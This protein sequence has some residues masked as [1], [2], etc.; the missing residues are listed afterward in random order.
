MAKTMRSASLDGFVPLARSCGLDPIKLLDKAGIPRDC[1]RNPDLRLSIG[2]Y[3]SLLE[4]SAKAAGADDFGVRL[5]ESRQLST[6][7]PVG[8]VVRE[9]PTVRKAIQALVDNIRLHNDS[10]S[11]ELDEAADDISIIKPDLATARG[12]PGAQAKDMVLGVVC[13][14]LTLL[15][16]PTWRPQSVW[17][18]RSRPA[19]LAAFRRVFGAQLEFNQDFNGIVCT[20][21]DI[22]QPIAGADPGMAREAER[23]VAL[24][25][26][27]GRR[28]GAEDIRSIVLTLLPTGQCTVEQVARHLG[29]DRRTVHRHLAAQDTTFSE[30]VDDLR[31]ELCISY[32][33]HGDRSLASVAELLGFSAQ[34]AFAHWHQERYGMSATARRVA[35]RRG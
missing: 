31:H 3:C 7:G 23:Y 30:I 13:R 35:A 27:T 17:F 29:V 10:A 21:R 19:N 20:R 14:I 24:L 22:D 33:E 2:A 8:L 4:A 12:V 9:Q 34:S 11:L 18:V 5:A 6:F 32:I 1:L 28:S 26:P 16:G 25:R 15:L